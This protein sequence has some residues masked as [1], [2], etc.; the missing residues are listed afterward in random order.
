MN[1]CFGCWLNQNS[2]YI[3]IWVYVHKISMDS[4]MIK[5]LNFYTVLILIILHT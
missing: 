3:K 1:E 4:V 5:A 2:I